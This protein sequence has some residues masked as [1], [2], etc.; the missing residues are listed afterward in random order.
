MSHGLGQLCLVHSDLTINTLAS[1]HFSL[2]ICAV[3]VKEKSNHSCDPSLV[4]THDTMPVSS[5]SRV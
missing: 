3:L 1:V 2:S 5:A 4:S